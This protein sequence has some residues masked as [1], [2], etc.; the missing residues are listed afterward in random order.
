[1]NKTIRSFIM[2]FSLVAMILVG[3]A[4]PRP[5]QASD[6]KGK[7]D[8]IHVEWT[9]T[10]QELQELLAQLKG[11]DVQFAE[12]T[13]KEAAA[14]PVTEKWTSKEMSAQALAEWVKNPPQRNMRAGHCFNI[15]IT[16]RIWVPI[17]HDFIT[18]EFTIRVCE[19]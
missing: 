13:S 8:A 5:L 10:E 17:F 3:V 2:L 15:T 7:D 14:I 1:M 19:E 16:G 18:F 6:E 4:L 9:A 12:G 11:Q